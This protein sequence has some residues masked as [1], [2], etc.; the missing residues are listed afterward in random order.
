MVQFGRTRTPLQWI[1]HIILGIVALLLVIWML[2]VY[3]L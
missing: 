1:G 3:V 2:R